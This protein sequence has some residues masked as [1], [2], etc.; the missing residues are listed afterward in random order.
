MRDNKVLEF[1]KRINWH[2]L[3]WR[4]AAFLIIIGVILIAVALWK[5]PNV[6]NLDRSDS[7]VQ[8]E[9]KTK[10]YHYDPYKEQKILIPDFSVARNTYDVN[11]FSQ[12]EQGFITYPNAKTGIDVSSHQQQ[13]DWKKVKQS[14]IDFAIIRVGLRG[15]TEGGIFI[16]DFFHEN[17]Q[18]AIANDIKVGAYFFSQAISTKEAIEEAEFVLE[19]VKDYTLSY[20]IVFDW[21]NVIHSEDAEPP[22]SNAVTPEEVSAFAAAFCETIKNA[23]EIPAYYVNKELGYNGLDL[24]MLEPYDLWYAEYQPKPSF[25]YHFDIWQY[26]ENGKVPGISTDVDINLSF[27]EYKE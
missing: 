27:K 24:E 6:F 14:G 8:L 2:W 26:T 25:Y 23:G 21:E 13:I 12:N 3:K 18:G 10:I 7:L 11:Q 20:P 1:V 9:Q 5:R 15:S 17:M 19:E 4:L 16:D 22:R